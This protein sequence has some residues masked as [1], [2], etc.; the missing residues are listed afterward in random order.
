MCFIFTKLQQHLKEENNTPVNCVHS[1]SEL[2]V[3]AMKTELD[4]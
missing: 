2:G 1:S 4:I 3:L